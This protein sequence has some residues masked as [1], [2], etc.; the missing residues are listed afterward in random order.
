[1]TVSQNVEQKMKVN[2]RSSSI[3]MCH[4]EVGYKWR[5]TFSEGHLE[6]FG[7]PMVL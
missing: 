1:M 3:Y 2:V 4:K 7:V 5:V 6:M